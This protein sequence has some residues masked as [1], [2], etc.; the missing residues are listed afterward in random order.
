MGDK[1]YTVTI[2]TDKDGKQEKHEEMV[3][4]DDN[5]MSHFTNNWSKGPTPQNDPNKWFP[6]DTFFK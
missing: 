2:R 1:Q 5:E 4:I 3:N 6:Y